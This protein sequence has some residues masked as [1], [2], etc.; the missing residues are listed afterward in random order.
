VFVRSEEQEMLS[1][2]FNVTV[3]K[4]TTSRKKRMMIINNIN[5]IQK[6]TKSSQEE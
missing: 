1:T 6:E 2:P 3:V 5:S 4:D